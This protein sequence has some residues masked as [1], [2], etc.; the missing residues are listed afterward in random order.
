MLFSGARLLFDLANTWEAFYKWISPLR[1]I[2]NV[3]K[4]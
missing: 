3:Q 1:F 2:H 4:G